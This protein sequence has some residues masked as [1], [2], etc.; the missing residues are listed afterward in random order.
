MPT[1]AAII[2]HGGVGTMMTA[3]Q[4]AVPQLVLPFDADQPELAERLARHGAGLAVPAAA[5]TGARVRANLLRLLADDG[6]RRRAEK[7]RAEVAAQPT[8][9]DLVPR[10]EELAAT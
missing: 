5:A 1:C 4:D 9:H 2:H 10:L 6:M 3:A 8:P 7:L